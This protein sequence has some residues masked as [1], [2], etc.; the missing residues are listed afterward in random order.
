MQPGTAAVL[1]VAY[2]LLYKLPGSRDLARLQE[3]PDHQ[4]R[5]IFRQDD[6]LGGTGLD[7]YAPVRA[8]SAVE[9]QEVNGRLDPGFQRLGNRRHQPGSR[10]DVLRAANGRL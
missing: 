8:G 3:H 2:D 5:V 4:P 10:Q 7:E 9:T 6:R 1:A